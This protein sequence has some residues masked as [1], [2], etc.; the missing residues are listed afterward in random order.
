[1]K[2]ANWYGIAS[3]GVITLCVAN[4]DQ[5]TTD[6]EDSEVVVMGKNDDNTNLM[7]TEKIDLSEGI[8]LNLKIYTTSSITLCSY[9]PP[10]P[11]LHRLTLKF[12]GQ[13][14]SLFL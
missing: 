4:S 14:L 9:R 8:R 7:S 12:I 3:N 1:M 5:L 13:P 10:L 6:M 2:V 11:G